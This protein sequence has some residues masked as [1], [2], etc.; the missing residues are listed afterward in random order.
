MKKLQEKIEANLNIVD[1]NDIS[2]F[3]LKSGFLQNCTF[4][5]KQLSILNFNSS[6]GKNICDLLEFNEKITI[7][8]ISPKYNNII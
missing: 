3:F 8:E 7:N 5:K 1:I 6:Y 4:S 2:S